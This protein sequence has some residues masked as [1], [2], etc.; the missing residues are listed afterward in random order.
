MLPVYVLTWKREMLVQ[1]VNKPCYS[2]LRR[3]Q[4]REYARSV[5][6]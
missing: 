3:S 1:A 2:A 6:P 5:N 4:V